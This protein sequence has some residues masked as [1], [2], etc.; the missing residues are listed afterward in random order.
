MRTA[1]RHT[2]TDVRQLKLQEQETTDLRISDLHKWQLA[3]DVPISELLV[4]PDYCLSPPVLERARLVRLMK[5]I[6]A[7]QQRASS[8]RIRRMAETAADQL[9]EIMP[10]LKEVSAWHEYGQR[11]SLNEYGRVVDRQV[12]DDLF[13][14]ACGGE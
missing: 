4:E 11:R 6:R 12:P 9:V 5:T 10:E 14:Q 3:L 2:G 13:H 1:A 7:I 8:I